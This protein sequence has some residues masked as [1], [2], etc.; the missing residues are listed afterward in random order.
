MFIRKDVHNY[1]M[2]KKKLYMFAMIFLILGAIN[3]V[4]IALFRVNIIQKLS[5]KESIAEIAYLFIGLAAFYVMFERD[6]YL[7]FLGRSILPCDV[8]KPSMP[9]DSTMKVTLKVKPDSKVIYW[10]SNPSVTGHIVDYKEAYGDFENSGIAVSDSNGLVEL[11][12]MEP[13]PYYVPYKGILPIHVH[14]RVCC[15]S[16]TVGPVRTAFLGSKKII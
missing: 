6:T 15:G 9:K 5:V 13:Q 14:Y 4:S 1:H 7:P 8:L 2:K 3:Y 11:P 16:G 10:A 12:I